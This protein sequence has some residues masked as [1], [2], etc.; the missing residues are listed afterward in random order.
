[1]LSGFINLYKEP[2]MSSNK[3]LSILKYHLKQNNI[4]TK[5]GHFGTL[6]PIAE[7]VLPV[8]L[9]RA[10]RLFPYSLDKKKRYIAELEFG[11]ETDTL[12]VTGEVVRIGRR[13]VDAE[14]IRAVLPSL[15]GRVMQIPP[16][17]SAKSVSGERAYKLA[18]RGE[19]FVLPPKEVYIYSIEIVGELSEGVFRLE[20]ECGGGTYIRSIV[21][22]I[23][24]K[25]DTVGSM[26]SLV[27]TA[28]G[29]FLLPDAVP[30]SELAKDP[31]KY[32]LP[33]EFLLKSFPSVDLSADKYVKIKN[34]IAVPCEE[35]GISSTVVVCAPDSTVMGLGEARNGQLCMKTWLL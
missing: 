3:A 30:L 31:A 19:E 11:K 23:A 2:G 25:L 15:I 14:E 33:A 32:I 22:D 16:N 17:Y 1:M 6:D 7:G 4:S 13:N 10:A 29:D 26:N 35:A 5:V 8:A 24:Y 21:R 28:S 20:I 18:R 12:D 34:G 27:R 9:G